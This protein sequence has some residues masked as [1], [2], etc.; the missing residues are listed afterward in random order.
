MRWATP[1]LKNGA[2]IGYVT[3]AL[4]HD[5]LME[6]TS[7]LMPT[8]TR[9]T[10]IPD[11]SSGNYAFIWDHKGRNIVHPRHFSIAGYDPETGDP[12]V[13]W[14]EDRIYNEW[15]ESKKSY[16]DF[17]EDVPTFMAQSNSKK[18]SAELTKQG[19]VGLDCR[20]LNFAAQCTG[21]FDLTQK[22][23]SGSFLI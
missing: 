23:G 13:P 21:W 17:I 11:A 7:H 5:H 15:Q 22:G 16:A 14:L 19:F 1:V 18:P 9:Y 3:L 6:F 12:Q 20:Y 8:N 2:I 4:N 10:E